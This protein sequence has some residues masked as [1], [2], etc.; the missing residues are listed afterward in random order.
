MR[1]EKADVA[2]LVSGG[3]HTDGITELLKD[4]NLSYVVITPKV[5]RLQEDNPYQSVLL[6]GENEFDIFYETL[7]KNSR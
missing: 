6:G 4:K 5:D 7:L 1:Q 3:F 2:V